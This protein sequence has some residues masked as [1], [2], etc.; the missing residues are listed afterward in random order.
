[1]FSFPLS[2]A[3]ESSYSNMGAS[4]QQIEDLNINKMRQKTASKK[5]WKV[6]NLSSSKERKIKL[7][8][9]KMT[10]STKVM[11]SETEL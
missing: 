10:A 9:K 1:M 8:M 4:H 6:E 7:D 3:N 11:N 5:V 2:D